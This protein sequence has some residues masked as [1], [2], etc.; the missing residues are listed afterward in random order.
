MT[1]T[2][3]RLALILTTIFVAACST[4]PYQLTSEQREYRWRHDSFTVLRVVA[5]YADPQQRSAAEV[6][7]AYQLARKG[8][9]VAR[10]KDGSDTGL[11]G[12]PGSASDA[13]TTPAGLLTVTTLDAASRDAVERRFAERGIA[14]LE[15][16]LVSPAPPQAQEKHFTLT[17]NAYLHVALFDA[18]TRSLVWQAS[19]DSYGTLTPQQQIN[20]LSLDI[21]R[22]LAQRGLI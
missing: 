15:E 10:G 19:S 21:V 4:E 5:L 11:A 9:D 17:K 7:F 1:E 16:M 18:R 6:A 3:K 8:V 2:L 22:T 20:A 12:F 13:E 14:A